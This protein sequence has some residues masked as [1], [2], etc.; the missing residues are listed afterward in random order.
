MSKTAKVQLTELA[1]RLRESAG[2]Y[3]EK[4]NGQDR[5]SCAVEFLSSLDESAAKLALDKLT[6]TMPEW[7]KVPN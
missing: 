7:F 5:H 2:V 6:D 1:A 4:A 3:R